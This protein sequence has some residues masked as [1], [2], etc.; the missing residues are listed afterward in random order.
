MYH[1]AVAC[2]IALSTYGAYE[3]GVY[4]EVQNLG[5]LAVRLVFWPV[6]TAAFRIFSKH[7]NPCP[8]R[9]P[10]SSSSDESLAFK[11]TTDLPG[12]HVAQ[13]MCGWYSLIGL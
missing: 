5:G 8:S 2:R 1:C 3:A 4:G 6:E 7:P 10:R 12:D 11:R 13:G 9:L